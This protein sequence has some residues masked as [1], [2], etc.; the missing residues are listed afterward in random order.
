M[1]QIL[2]QILADVAVASPTVQTPDML[3][4]QAFDQLKQRDFDAAEIT[5][6]QFLARYPDNA[7]AGNAMYWLGETLYA[8]ARFG[9]A[10][11]IFVKSY[12]QYPTGAKASHSLLKLG[13]SLKNLN[14]NEA[15]CRCF[16]NWSINF[17]MPNS[18]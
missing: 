17:P 11:D 13:M 1:G 8:R 10:A 15:A 7:L 5:L 9:E 18:G 12:T 2:G 4:R 14:E 16:P 3:Y 6:N